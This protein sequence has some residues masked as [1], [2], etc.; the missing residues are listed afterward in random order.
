[1]KLK[2]FLAIPVKPD[3]LPARMTPGGRIV[4]VACGVRCVDCGEQI[5]CFDVSVCNS[6]ES[7]KVICSFCG[8]TIFAVDDAQ[9]FA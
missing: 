5:R 9:P 3:A 4:S 1:M 8:R 2:T 7:L 6:D